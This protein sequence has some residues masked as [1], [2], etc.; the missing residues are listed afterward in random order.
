MKSGYDFG[1]RSFIDTMQ[2]HRSLLHQSGHG[3]GNLFKIGTK[4][5][6]KAVAKH[7]IPFAVQ[8]VGGSLERKHTQQAQQTGQGFMG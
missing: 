2:Y 3:W 8:E 4:A 5:V 7:A 1:S 6:A